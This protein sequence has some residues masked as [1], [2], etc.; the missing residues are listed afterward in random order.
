MTDAIAL[1]KVLCVDDEPA[2]LDSLERVLRR[3]F[4]V[5][6]ATHPDLAL[7]LLNQNKDVSVIISDQRMPGRSGLEFLAE[8][9]KIAPHAV[10]AIVSAHIDLSDMTEAINSTQI[11]RFI[12][13]PWDADYLRLQIL[14]AY[15]NHELLRT[16]SELERLAITDPVTGLT[17]HRFF[18]EY[19]RTEIERSQRH[20]RC[21]ALIFCDIDHFKEVNDQFG[22]PFGDR[23]LAEI[24]RRLAQQVRTIDS[25]SRY[26]GEEF[27]LVL[28]DTSL[29]DAEQMAERIRISIANT[30]LT[31]PHGEPLSITLSF[32]V[33]SYPDSATSA[34]TLI[35]K[36]DRALYRAK[37]QG[38]NATVVAE[39]A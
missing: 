13:K 33:A 12:L 10:R 25:V 34:D 23:L 39:P 11:H 22:H 24:S 31:G 18:Q 27:A 9:K 35:E 4:Q 16:N 37:G 19:L 29:L 17:N 15:K 38:R 1:P 20:R 28:P 3:H 2:M 26:G 7:E 14:E 8:A 21:L 6:R 30:R 5:L 36:A 32:G